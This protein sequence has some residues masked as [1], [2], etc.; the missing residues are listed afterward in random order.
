MEIE[1]WQKELE[2]YLNEVMAEIGVLNDAKEACERALEA[3]VIPTEMVT[4]CIALRE[5]RREFE[6]VK[7]SVEH[8]LRAEQ[9]LLEEIRVKLKVSWYILQ[10]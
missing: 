4:E 5:G 9:Q 8:S 6:V 7:D 2:K 10:L 3:K 1:R